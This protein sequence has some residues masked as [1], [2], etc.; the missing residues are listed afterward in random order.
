MAPQ[1]P[2]RLSGLY[3]FL[4]PTAD[5]SQHPALKLGVGTAIENQDRIVAVDW[6]S[7]MCQ[8]GQ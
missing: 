2:D 6:L 8:N 1:P 4:M 3:R 7:R 5:P